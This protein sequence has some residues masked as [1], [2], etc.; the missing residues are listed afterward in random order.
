M[1]I[2]LCSCEK[3]IRFYLSYKVPRLVFLAVADVYMPGAIA[4]G[5]SFLGHIERKL[6]RQAVVRL[7]DLPISLSL[8]SFY[9]LSVR[10]SIGLSG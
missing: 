6:L 8:I 10:F 2:R 1:V 9:D 4:L 7:L 3:P 5:S